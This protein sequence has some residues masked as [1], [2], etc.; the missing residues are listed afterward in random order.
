MDEGGYA[1]DAPEKRLLRSLVDVLPPH[2]RLCQYLE[3]LHQTQ[4]YAAE[5]VLHLVNGGMT[6]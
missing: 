2:R 4:K 1:E 6:M 5:R 3:E